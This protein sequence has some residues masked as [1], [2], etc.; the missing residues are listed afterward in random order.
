M[1]S[2][3]V[4]AL[5]VGRRLHVRAA[6]S[7]SPAGA[8]LRQLDGRPR[9]GRFLEARGLRSHLARR[10]ASLRVPH[11]AIPGVRRTE[12]ESRIVLRAWPREHLA[13][14][15]RAR[16]PDREVGGRAW[17]RDAHPTP[18]GF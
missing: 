11:L 18:P 8:G 10:R 15:Q 16:R 4:V 12:R 6:G 2:A 3:E 7:D 14:Y 1:W 9:I 17:S 13:A 5:A